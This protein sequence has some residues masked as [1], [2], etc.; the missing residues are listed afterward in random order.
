MNLFFSLIYSAH[1]GGP[2]PR[3][4][5]NNNTFIPKAVSLPSFSFFTVKVSQ[6][7]LRSTLLTHARTNERTKR[8]SVG[9]TDDG[10]DGEGATLIS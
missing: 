9:R 2:L 3:P 1:V 10:R 4:A 8:R 7:L 5:R 6:A